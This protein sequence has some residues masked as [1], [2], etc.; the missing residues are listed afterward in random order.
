MICSFVFV[1]VP[2]SM[3]STFWQEP[4]LWCA[5]MCGAVLAA[6]QLAVC[7][8]QQV[9]A[10]VLEEP[11]AVLVEVVRILPKLPIAVSDHNSI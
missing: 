11:V 7:A 10:L 5:E 9:V 1:H 4:L 2:L 6:K 3:A 8:A